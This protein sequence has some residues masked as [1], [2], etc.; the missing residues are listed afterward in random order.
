M[1]IG[2]RHR[3]TAGGALTIGGRPQS[4]EVRLGE[5]AYLASVQHT[6]WMLLNQLVR[7]SGAVAKVTL[8]V[9]ANIPVIPKL[10]PLIA[11]EKPL[12]ESL[13]E[14][15]SAV[16]VPADDFVPV[17]VRDAESPKPDVIVAIG[18]HVDP[19]ATCCC[20]G[21]G[22]CGGIFD[23]EISRPNT[24][25]GLTIGPYIAAS[26]VAGEVFRAA[27]LID[28]R[29]EHQLFFNASDYTATTQPGW[30]DLAINEELSSVA[31]IGV[32]AVGSAVLHSLYPLRLRGNIMVADNDK[33]GLEDTNLGRYVLFGSRSLTKMKASEAARLLAGASFTVTPHDGGFDYF[34]ESGRP[35][36]VLSAVDKNGPRH[37]LQEQYAPL[38]LSA[39][40]YNLRA[41]VLRCV[42]P[43][44]GGC[45]ACFNPLEKEERTE[46]K[47]RALLASDPAIAQAIATKLQLE[48]EELAAWSRN[49]RCNETG[50]RVVAAFRTDDGVVA[51][52]AVVFVS[53]L[54]GT[55]LAAEL[56][57]TVA[58]STLPLNEDVNRVVFQFHNPSAQMNRASFYGRSDSC[59]SC[60]TANYG[61]DV[62]K[63]RYAEFKQRKHP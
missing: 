18:F 16:G 1:D 47:I 27:R 50:E 19:D 60:S 52:F 17:E 43:G 39:S 23:R 46:D 26:L 63:R 15:A 14:G 62:W 57:K 58:G 41:E 8:V 22:L 59:T 49:R 51:A 40:T 4:V 38:Y 33:K 35:D 24:D 25:C 36:I 45:L 20:A 29:P 53:V 6:A 61:T 42:P 12:L 10:S 55:I 2:N 3:G 56:L 11:G 54:A 44:V 5:D 32:G 21:W 30:T 28:Y 9:P 48:P 34:F 31:L 37:A 13:L 7:L